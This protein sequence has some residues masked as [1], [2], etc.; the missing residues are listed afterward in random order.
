MILLVTGSSIE[1]TLFHVGCRPSLH[2]GILQHLYLTLSYNGPPNSY[3]W[4]CRNQSY[5]HI[6]KARLELTSNHVGTPPTT[7][8]ERPST[9]IRQPML[10]RLQHLHSAMRGTNPPCRKALQ[11]HLTTNV[12]KAQ[13]LYSTVQGTNPSCRKGSAL[14]SKNQC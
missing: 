3:I 11:L 7:L 1:P 14:T 6:R 2:V 5:N 8:L 10:E 13:H 4:S 12:R 9:H